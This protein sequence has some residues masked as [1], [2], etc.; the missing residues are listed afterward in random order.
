LH[1]GGLPSQGRIDLGELVL[2]SGEADLRS[3]DLAEPAFPLRLGDAVVQVGADLLQPGALGGIRPQERA[4]DTSVLVN[5]G[6]PERAGAATIRR[7]GR[8]RG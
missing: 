2:G 5:A 1:G 4:P 3:L 6:R 7:R 8:L